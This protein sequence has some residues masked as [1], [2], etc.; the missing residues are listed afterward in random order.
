MATVHILDTTITNGLATIKPTEG[1]PSGQIYTYDGGRST[2]LTSLDYT[3]I[4]STF[5]IPKVEVIS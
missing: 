4:E 1:N 3:T 2:T 5:G